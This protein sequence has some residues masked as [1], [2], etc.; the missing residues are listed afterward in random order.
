MVDMID[1]YKYELAKQGKQKIKTTRKMIDGGVENEK[2]YTLSEED[3]N[4][5]FDILETEIGDL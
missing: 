5:I 1:S 3:K 4:S 2:S